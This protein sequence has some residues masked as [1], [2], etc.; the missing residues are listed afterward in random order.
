[1]DFDQLES[2]LE[3]ARLSSFCAAE[4]FLSLTMVIDHGT[5]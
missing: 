4:K 5:I 1:M 2:F 3:V